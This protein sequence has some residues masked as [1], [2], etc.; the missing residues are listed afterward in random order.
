[1]SLH[2]LQVHSDYVDGCFGCKVGTLQLNA[3]DA[4]SN[5]EVS[6]AKWNAE[7]NAYANA[8]SQGIQPAGTRM[9]QIKAA[10]E[11]SD[12][13]GRAYDAGTMPKAEKITK[14]HGDVMKE[15]GI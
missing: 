6:K 14:R 11:A 5:R 15:V 7:L 10:V 4:A 3:G 1:M 12:K 9:G 2:R 13:L 8:R